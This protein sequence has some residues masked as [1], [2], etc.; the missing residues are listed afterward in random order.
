MK[1]FLILALS[2]V[3]F[4]C[5][6][7][8][9]TIPQPNTAITFNIAPEY[10]GVASKAK[11]DAWESGDVILLFFSGVATPKHLKMSY[12]GTSWTYTEMDGSTSGSLGLKN[13]DSGKL[14]AVYLPFG[15][16]ATVRA[17]STSAGEYETGFYLTEYYTYYLRTANV[18]YTVTDNS[19]SLSLVL[20]LPEGSV[21]FFVKDS[22]AVLR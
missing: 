14:V 1:R 5:T 17:G 6:R 9:V 3:L 12:D 21:Q 4:S 19:L 13:G 11:K 16:D 15:S 22:K 2:A 18:S 10:E 8:P 20:R 7:E